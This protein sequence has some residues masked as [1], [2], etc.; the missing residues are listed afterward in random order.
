MVT[1]QRQERV[2]QI[3]SN[4]AKRCVNPHGHTY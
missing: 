4:E 3:P 2:T 1:K